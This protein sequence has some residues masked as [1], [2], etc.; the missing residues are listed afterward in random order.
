MGRVIRKKIVCITCL[1]FCSTFIKPLNGIL[2]DTIYNKANVGWMIMW[3]NGFFLVWLKELIN[4]LVSVWRG[5]SLVVSRGLWPLCTYGGR[6]GL[7]PSI[8]TKTTKQKN[9]KKPQDDIT[10]EM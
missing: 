2:I 8:M 10:V 4:G 1:D 5:A 6:V 9:T 3:L 7:L